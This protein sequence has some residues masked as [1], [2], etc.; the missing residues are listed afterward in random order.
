M[1]KNILKNFSIIFQVILF[2]SL[3]LKFYINIKYKKIQELKTEIKNLEEEIYQIEVI[4]NNKKE[5]L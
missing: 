5:N 1:N 4:I 3:V 2:F